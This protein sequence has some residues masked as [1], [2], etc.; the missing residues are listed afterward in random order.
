MAADDWQLLVRLVA[1]PQ[2][3][4]YG[5]FR[6]WQALPCVTVRFAADQ[7]G[8]FRRSAEDMARPK[9]Y[10]STPSTT[11]D[12]ATSPNTMTLARHKNCCRALRLS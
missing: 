6:A 3:R 11:P 4:H 9:S 8:E 1:A 2:R 7:A 12:A 10:F 5:L